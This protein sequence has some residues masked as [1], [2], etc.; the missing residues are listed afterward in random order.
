M[1]S[2]VYIIEQKYFFPIQ[3]RYICK[4]SAKDLEVWTIFTYIIN[5]KHLADIF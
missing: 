3:H 4:M 2:L 1:L 5:R